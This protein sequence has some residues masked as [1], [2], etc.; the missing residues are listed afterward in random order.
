MSQLEFWMIAI[1]C[2]IALTLLA[3]CLYEWQE[4]RSE[5]R[6][7]EERVRALRQWDQKNKGRRWNWEDWRE[8]GRL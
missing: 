6:A 3:H 1:F 7:M 5:R 4:R 8:R 2:G